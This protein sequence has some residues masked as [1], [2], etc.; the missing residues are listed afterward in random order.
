ME[1][2]ADTAQADKFL[3]VVGRFS[4][5]FRTLLQNA[6]LIAHD[7]QSNYLPKTADFIELLNRYALDEKATRFRIFVKEAI[8]REG[9]DASKKT[10]A[11]LEGLRGKT[12]SAFD[13]GQGT[14]MMGSIVPFLLRGVTYSVKIGD[15]SDKRESFDPSMFYLNRLTSGALGTSNDLL[16]AI[17]LLFELKC[18]LKTAEKVSPD[19]FLLHGPL[20]RSLAQYSIYSLSEKDIKS[21]LDDEKLFGDFEHYLA[22]KDS[23]VVIR[24]GN[25]R[26]RGKYTFFAAIVFIL[27]RLLT[28][29]KEK[30]TI[31]CG[32]VER[33][34][35]SE[36]MQRVLYDNF[37]ELYAG[38][39]DWFRRAVGKE[40]TSS[41]N[42]E[43]IRYVK[44]FIDNLGYTD[45][46]IL[47]PMLANG[48]FL[49]P[50]D[51][52][53]N[54]SQKVN[55]ELGIDT[56]FIVG[57][58][59]LSE[60]IPNFKFSY[61]RTSMFNTPFKVEMPEW[62]TKEDVKLLMESIFAFSQFLPHYA[63]PVNLDIVD[64]VAKVPQWMSRAMQGMILGEIYESSNIQDAPSGIDY[65]LLLGSKSR[66]WNLRPIV[67]KT[68]T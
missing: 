13:G 51:G 47:G 39:K 27:D 23:S 1:F 16:G 33:S 4:D 64:K 18:A 34:N 9:E 54:K 37:D 7:I 3:H 50:V 5:V 46:L 26:L 32:V 28:V 63:F 20:V 68:L 31:I 15:K 29:A 14:A 6:P 38:E 35:S 17:Q 30:G 52:R 55:R 36:L 60:M 59:E 62:F 24:D 58:E 2:E 45:P 56:G 49:H 66:D 21:I 48:E 40:F 67:S 41:Q 42:L 8:L 57:M 12:V 43:R 65:S 10:V 19:I 61:V 25:E 44:A 11:T 22:D 53:V